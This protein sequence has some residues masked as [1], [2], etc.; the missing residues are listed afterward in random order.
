MIGIN[1]KQYKKQNHL[2]GLIFDIKFFLFGS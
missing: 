1:K 2:M